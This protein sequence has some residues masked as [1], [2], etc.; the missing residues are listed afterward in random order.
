ME[1]QSCNNTSIV[2]KVKIMKKAL[3]TGSFDPPTHGHLSI[4]KR[5]A[6]LCDKLYVGI[7]I[8]PAKIETSLLSN[9]KKKML[10]EKLTK[11]IKNIEVVLFEGLV[12][13]FTKTNEIDFLIRGLRA[14]S[15][16][17]YE[18]RMAIANK[19][20]ADIDTIFLMAD[21]EH[22]H[23]N[24][25]LIREIAYFDGPIEKFVPQEVAEALKQN[26]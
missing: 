26:S 23:I 10:L 18:F 6:R 13:D 20:L 22:T 2:F 5:A 25:S 17:E 8:N 15:D 24:S 3:L 1:V 4:I 14:F 11:D 9:A 12:S 16:F 7:A 21:V 19:K